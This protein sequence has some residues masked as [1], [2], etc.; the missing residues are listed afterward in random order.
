MCDDNQLVSLDIS[1]NNSLA[2]FSCINNPLECIQVADISYAQQQESLLAESPVDC[3]YV[4]PGFN[5]F[6]QPNS[7]FKR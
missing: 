1:Q 4:N 7:C 5:E 3:W 6:N 2:L